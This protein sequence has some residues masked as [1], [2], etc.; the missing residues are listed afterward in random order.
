V[1]AVV[2]VPAVLAAEPVTLSVHSV[3]GGGTA[4]LTT[5]ALTGSP[6]N[7]GEVTLPSDGSAVLIEVSG[8]TARQNYLA[9]ISVF[10]S[11]SAWNTLRAE[12][13]DPLDD[14]DALDMAPY[15]SG[16]PAGYTTSNTR[17]GFSFAQSAGLERSAEWAGGSGT[18][19]ADETTNGADALLFTGVAGASGALRVTFG[20]RDYDGGRSF[21]IRLS[22]EDGMAATP[23][24]ASMLLIGTG[25]AGIVAARRRRRV[26]AVSGAE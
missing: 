4:D 11:T 24:P 25:L 5:G 3:T 9:E 12:V 6:L 15:H 16:V 1:A 17:D 14:D 10:G 21:L 26:T 13:L 20:L 8:L 2:L 22:A 7:L 19:M 23:E 18:V